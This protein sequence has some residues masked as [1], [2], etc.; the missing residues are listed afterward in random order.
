ME[1]NVAP[2]YS[3][4]ANIT[5]V[6]QAV[7][8]DLAIETISF[9]N[10]NFLIGTSTPNTPIVWQN[11]NAGQYQVIF[12]PSYLSFTAKIK[13]IIIRMKKMPVYR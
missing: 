1:P 4:P 10:N 5:L 8:T 9:Y 2:A 6:C 12:T 3:S 7:R 11:V 13:A